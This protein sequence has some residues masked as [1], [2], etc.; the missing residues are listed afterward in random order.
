MLGIYLY[1]IQAPFQV[2]LEES[3]AV[4]AVR[5]AVQK[6]ERWSGSRRW[7]RRKDG[8]EKEL[9]ECKWWNLLESKGNDG[10]RGGAA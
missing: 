3:E 10:K 6:V 7:E 4:E 2:R 9:G 8:R 5:E 1:S